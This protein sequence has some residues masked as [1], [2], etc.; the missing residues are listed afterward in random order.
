MSGGIYAK[1]KALVPD[2]LRSFSSIVLILITAACDNLRN[3][4]GVMTDR[5][6]DRGDGELDAARP[7]WSI[8]DDAAEDFPC[9]AEMNL[10]LWGQG[11]VREPLVL[12]SQTRRRNLHR[13]EC[14]VRQGR[15]PGAAVVIGDRLKNGHDEIGSRVVGEADPRQNLARFD[16]RPGDRLALGPRTRNSVSINGPRVRSTDCASR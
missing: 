6:I 11:R 5:V 13:A 15:D 7:F 16:S 9:G 1:A 4:L 12:N 10:A 8:G 14:V 2:I 3:P